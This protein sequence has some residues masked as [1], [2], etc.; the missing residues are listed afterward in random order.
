MPQNKIKKEL[1]LG[2][3]HESICLNAVAENHYFKLLARSCHSFIKNLG[4][5]SSHLT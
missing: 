5:A 1:M 2:D 3:K 4:I